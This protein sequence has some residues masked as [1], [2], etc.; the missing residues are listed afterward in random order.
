MHLKSNF[1][2]LRRS[3]TEG[4]G[5]GVVARKSFDYVQDSPSLEQIHPGFPP[6]YRNRSHFSEELGRTRNNPQNES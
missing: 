5:V 3:T 4:G 1:S 2:D 6:Y